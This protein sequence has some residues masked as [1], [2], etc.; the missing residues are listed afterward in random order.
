MYEREQT[1]FLNIDLDILSTSPLEPLVEALGRKVRVLYVGKERRRF[2]AHL[3]ISGSGYRSNADRLMRRLVALVKTLPRTG[4]ILWD[5]AQSR[6]FNVGI[7]AAVNGTVFELRLQLETLEAVTSVRGR[8]V[9][10]V[11]AP[12]GPLSAAARKRGNK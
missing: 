5:T 10:T 11:Y 8:I 7:E 9:V 12:A 2:G 3:E 4:R 1:K 6:E